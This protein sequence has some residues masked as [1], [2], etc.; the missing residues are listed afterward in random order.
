MAYFNL[1]VGLTELGK[2]VAT[3]GKE[4]SVYDVERSMTNP[5][6]VTN[7]IDVILEPTIKLFRGNIWCFKVMQNG[8]FDANDQFKRTMQYLIQYS[9]LW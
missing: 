7:Y 1:A 8:G 4:K 3:S 6:P 9:R 2:V 5:N